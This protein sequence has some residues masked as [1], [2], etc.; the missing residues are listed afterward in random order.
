MKK[1]LS[2]ICVAVIALTAASCKKETVVQ[3]GNTNRTVYATNVSNWQ[4]VTDGGGSYVMDINVPALDKTYSENGAVLV[5]IAPPGST[6]WE[7]IPETFNG[8]AY[9]FTHDV[10]RVSIYA[11]NPSGS[12]TPVLPPAIDVKIVLIDSNIN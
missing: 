3:G 4:L 8:R 7:Q 9:S 2:I 10:G 5:Y 1:L 12:G 6:E 11:Q